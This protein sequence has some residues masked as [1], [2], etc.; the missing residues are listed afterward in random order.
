MPVDLGLVRARLRAAGEPDG[1]A[2]E[3]A[4]AILMDAVG[5]S[6]F[7]IWL[8]P[9][10]LIAVDLQGTLVVSAPPETL[11]WVARRFGRILDS[12][13]ERAGRRL[14]IADELER[15]AGEAMSSTDAADLAKPSSSGSGQASSG[16]SAGVSSGESG[17]PP[18]D[19][20]AYPTSCT[21]VY[22]QFEEV[23][24]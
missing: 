9:L 24:C 20:S 6:T 22:N 3:Q 7:E 17:D 12:A 23:S 19:G 8:A 5:E 14:R 11:G 4:R 10:E 16:S 1:A 21:D 15:Q 13:A 18:V 2:W